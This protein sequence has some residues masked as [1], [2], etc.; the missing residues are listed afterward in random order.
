M[1]LT[2]VL[3]KIFAW[4]FYKEHSGLLLFFYVTVISYCFFIKTAGVYKQE[5]SV[6][7]HL[8]LMMTFINTP[9]IMLVVFTLWLIYTIK[10]WQFVGRQLRMEN[11]RFLFYSATSYSKRIQLVSWFCV[12]LAIS[13]PLIGYWL[14]ATLLGLFYHANLIPLITLGYILLVSSVSS[15]FY[16][17]R[18]NYIGKPAKESFFIKLSRYWVKP[19]SG[20]FLYYLADKLKTTYLL[21][22][23]LSWLAITGVT[24][25]FAD[26]SGDDRIPAIVMLAVVVLHSFLIYKEYYFKESYLSISRNLPY[27]RIKLFFNFSFVFMLLIAPEVVWFFINYTITTAFTVLF[28]GLSTALLFRSLLYAIGLKIYRYLLWVFCLFVVMFYMIMFGVLSLLTGLNLIVAFF[29]FYNY[30]YRPKMSIRE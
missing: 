5:E 24:V 25:A 28:T 30:Y 20:L 18:A 27:K 21:I 9:V 10:S 4:R 8:M 23:L 12:H 7:Y 29:I 26:F 14:F 19:F 1:A 22:K 17:Y 2:N 16:V 13:L 3:L 15:L 11:N 6:F